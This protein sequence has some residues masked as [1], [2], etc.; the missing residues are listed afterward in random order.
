MPAGALDG[1]AVG[2]VRLQ[3]DG[4]GARVGGRLEDTHG[5]AE[6]AV[7]VGRH[8]GHYVRRCLWSDAAAGNFEALVAHCAVPLIDSTGAVGSR[9]P[10]F[11]FSA[12]RYALS[13][14]LQNGDSRAFCES[15]V[16]SSKMSVG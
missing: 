6:I 12:G 7:V 16:W 4:V 3:L 14:L 1:H 15:P 10:R 2:C 13:G 8:F 11:G 5:P 9:S